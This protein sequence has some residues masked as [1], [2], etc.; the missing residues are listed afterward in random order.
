MPSC[1]KGDG[2][3]SVAEAGGGQTRREAELMMATEVEEWLPSLSFHS[4]IS[5]HHCHIGLGKKKRT[6]RLIPLPLLVAFC[7][8]S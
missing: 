4:V 1:A 6:F 3:G 2:S 8:F 5:H 7:I